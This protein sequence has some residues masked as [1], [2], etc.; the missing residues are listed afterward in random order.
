MAIAVTS[1]AFEETMGFAIAMN[2]RHRL[3]QRA[4]VRVLGV[5]STLNC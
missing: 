4:G 5:A 2:E 3:A 1:Q